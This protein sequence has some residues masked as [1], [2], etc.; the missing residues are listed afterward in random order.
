[1]FSPLQIDSE[2]YAYNFKEDSFAAECF[3]ISGS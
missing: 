1:M 3:Y 2:I